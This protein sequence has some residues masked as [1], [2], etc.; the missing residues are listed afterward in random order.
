MDRVSNSSVAKPQYSQ[1]PQPAPAPRNDRARA[2]ANLSPEQ[3][4]AESVAKKPK[5]AVKTLGSR[6]DV[7]A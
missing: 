2:Y 1:E 5:A 7:Y 6:I 4:R 3:Q